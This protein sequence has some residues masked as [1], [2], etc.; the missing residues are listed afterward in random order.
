MSDTT[1]VKSLLIKENQG[2]P[3]SPR[4]RVGKGKKEHERQS[5]GEKGPER[6][7]KCISLSLLSFDFPYRPPS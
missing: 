1:F 7:L 3:W 4:E 2:S 5:G 6:R